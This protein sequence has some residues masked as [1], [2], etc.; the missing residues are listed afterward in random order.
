MKTRCYN[1][2][3]RFFE[4]YGKN[5]ILMCDE[6]LNSFQTFR[7][8]SESH[9]YA[10]NLTL[11]RIDNNGNYCPE[12]CRWVDMK[13]QTNNRKSNRIIEFRGENKTVTEWAEVF[14]INVSTLWSRLEKGLDI[15]T[16]LTT[17]INTNKRR[18]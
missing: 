15:E 1:R 7:D 17:P 8:W 10:D 11:D 5:G 12:N 4:F 14:G 9:G 6:W 18:K 16:A 13:T 3:N 2:K